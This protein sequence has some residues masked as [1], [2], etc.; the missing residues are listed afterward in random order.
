MNSS[1][2]IWLLATVLAAVAYPASRE[3][4]SNSPSERTVC[5]HLYDFAHTTSSDLT[6]A[7]PQASRTF[8]A[9]GIRIKW[10][11]PDDSKEAHLL[12]FTPSGPTLTSSDLQPCVVVR[13]TRNEVH[14]SYAD[15][16]GF[17]L[18][19][20]TE[21]INVEIFYQRIQN[22]ASLTGLP[23]YVLLGAVMTHEVGHVLLQSAAHS[24]AG[25]M[26][27]HWDRES[28]R[29]A[30]FG[31]LKF[32]PCEASRMRENTSALHQDGAEIHHRVEFGPGQTIFRGSSL[33][34]LPNRGRHRH[35]S[36]PASCRWPRGEHF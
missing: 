26:R 10:E 28:V 32:L 24:A 12:D 33:L 23:I 8:S 35:S 25:I 5:I 13:I 21:G 29:L 7:T 31:L 11:Q 36:E 9:A 16:L 15:A 2:R 3:S 22:Q 14:G 20:A 19:F 34:E 4:A 27:D 1:A 18:P 17:A 6:W 30:S